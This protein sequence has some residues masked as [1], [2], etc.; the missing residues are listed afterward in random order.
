MKR[1]ATHIATRVA[2]LLNWPKGAAAG[3]AVT[4]E[5]TEA[6]KARQ[7]LPFPSASSVGL[8][9]TCRGAVGRQEPRLAL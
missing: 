2:K 8:P 6:S 3:A 7:V 4:I 5:R 1:C 9:V